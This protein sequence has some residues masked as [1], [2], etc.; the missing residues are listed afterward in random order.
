MNSGGRW[1]AA[2]ALGLLLFVSAALADRRRDRRTNLD[3]PG[4]MPWTALQV[5]AAMLAILAVALALSG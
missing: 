2:A 5:F 1:W 3:R 4:W